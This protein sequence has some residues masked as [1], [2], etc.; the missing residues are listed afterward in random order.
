MSPSCRRAFRSFLLSLAVAGAGS[1]CAHKS[2]S[3]ALTGDEQRLRQDLFTPVTFIQH[4]DTSV[5]GT[6]LAQNVYSP[7]VETLRA[8]IEDRDGVKLKSRGEAHITVINPGEYDR[9]LK[10]RLSMARISQLAREAGIQQLPFRPLCLGKGTRAVG[11]QTDLTYF[12][13]VEAPG[14]AELRKKIGEAFVQAGGDPREFDAGFF[15]P[16]ITVGFT[17]RDL[18]VEDGVT[19][20]ARSCVR[21]FTL[22]SP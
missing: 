12:I 17:D 13:V 4:E 15:E 1:G 14:L 18:H 8:D 16:H 22:I 10:Q 5:A 21:N 19:K 6:Y 7:A 2:A 9:A 3:P 11:S 20:D